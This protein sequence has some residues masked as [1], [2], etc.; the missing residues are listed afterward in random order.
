MNASILGFEAIP[1]CA[2]RWRSFIWI[3]RPLAYD[4][5][6]LR[7]GASFGISVYPAD[8]DNTDALLQ[9]ADEDIYRAKLEHRKLHASAAHESAAA[10][11]A[12]KAEPER[13]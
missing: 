5:R 2:A 7:I 1:P 3:L 11:F 12:A 6:E 4:D 13:C 9:I 8:G 10:V